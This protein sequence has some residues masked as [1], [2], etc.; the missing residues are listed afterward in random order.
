MLE[1]PG[2]GWEGPRNDQVT[3]KKAITLS[4]I[5][6]KIYA[7]MGPTRKMAPNFYFYTVYGSNDT[8][9]RLGSLGYEI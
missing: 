7:K 2:E 3:P 1:P 5:C 9:V 6:L 4:D 8:G